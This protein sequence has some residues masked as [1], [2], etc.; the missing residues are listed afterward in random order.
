MNDVFDV[1]DRNIIR[2]IHSSKH[3]S[4]GVYGVAIGRE[5]ATEYHASNT[6][7]RIRSNCFS[8]AMLGN[9]NI[10]PQCGTKIFRFFRITFLF[11]CY[12]TDVIKVFVNGIYSISIIFN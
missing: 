2:V 11:A 7:I 9:R 6:V 1:V 8:C 12:K 4:Y 5:L 10:I 3:T